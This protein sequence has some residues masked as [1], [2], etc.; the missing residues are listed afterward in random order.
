MREQWC[1][2]GE[3]RNINIQKKIRKVKMTVALII[4]KLCVSAVFKKEGMPPEM[5]K[6]LKIRD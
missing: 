2:E 5:R 1:E 6:G 3:G 4:L